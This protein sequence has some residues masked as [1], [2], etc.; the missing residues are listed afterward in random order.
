MVSWPAC[1]KNL[2]LTLTCIFYSCV[3]KSSGRKIR[4]KLCGP[5]STRPKGKKRKCNLY[6]CDFEWAVDRWEQC[7]HT[8]GAQG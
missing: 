7:T 5:K 2:E 3:D 4:K 6:S 1:R 8:C